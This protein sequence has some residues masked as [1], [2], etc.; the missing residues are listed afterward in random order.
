[1]QP[2]NVM[3]TEF[4]KNNYL[5]FSFSTVSTCSVLGL[6][7]IL[8]MN[9][10][11]VAEEFFNPS[12]LSEDP[13][14]VADLSRF[15]NDGAQAPGKYRVDVYVNENYLSTRDVTFISRSDKKS[16]STVQNEKKSDD[17]GLKACFTLRQLER[18]GVDFHGTPLS[19][20]QS[21]SDCF[22]FVDA[23]PQSASRFDFDKL[24]LYISIPQANM[25]SSVRGYIPPEEW[26]EGVPALLLNYNFSGSNAHSD[27]SSGTLSSYF[28][29]VK[30]GANW[31]AWRLR[32]YST[33]SYS[34]Q[35]RS[36]TNQWQNISTFMQR[37]VIPLK[38]TLQLGDSDTQSDIFDGHGFRGIQLASDDNMMPDSMRGFAPI[39]RGVAN[40]NAQVTV[41]QNGYTIYQSYVSPGAF[42]INDL[43]STASSG[44]LQVTVK[45]A[46]GTENTFTVP[47]SA[48]PILQR[49]GRLKYTLTVGQFRSNNTSQKKP[50]FG[51]GTAIIGLPGGITLYG[52][53]QLANHYRSFVLGSGFN[54]GP[55]GAVSADITQ[56]NSTLADNSQHQ[57]QSLRFL[58]AKS[59]ND[60]G[61]NFQLLGYRYSTQGFYTLDET[62]YRTM[63]GYN[64]SR[65]DDPKDVNESGYGDYYNLRYS[66]KGRVQ[67]NITQQVGKSGSIYL[68]GSRQSYWHNDQTNDLWQVGFNGFW[69]DIN[70]SLSWSYNKNP[71]YSDAD[72]R[73]ALNLSLP[74]GKWLTRGGK[75]A[76][77]T[78][79]NNSAYA[80]YSA[81]RDS[82]GN[83]TQQAGVS[84]TL[85]DSNNLNYN[86]QQGYGNHGVGGSGNAGLDYQGRYG[87]SNV[88]YSYSREYRQLNYGLSGGVV[89]H[90]NGITLSQPLGD[91]NV[92]IKAPGASSVDLENTTGV[93]TDWRG[94]AVMPY[95]N[96][97][98]LNRIALDTTSLKDDADV[99]DAVTNVVP[100]WGALSLAEFTTRIGRRGLITLS[101]P[102]GKF[103]P[104]GA[105]ASTDDSRSQSIVGENGQVYLSGLLPEG[106]LEVKWGQGANQM[107]RAKYILPK[108]AEGKPIAFA[109]SVC[110]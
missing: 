62:S 32:N 55:F 104:F 59:L 26:D 38:S 102:N 64:T 35:N 14:A 25:K 67:V 7:M 56:A 17:T 103:V 15:S 92:L 13:D 5:K 6:C 78:S 28:L 77:I 22:D 20:N 109:T 16:K 43:Y 53:S 2:F 105:V 88:N 18:L 61:T 1:M 69:N 68:S 98:R 83:L 70:Y 100:T 94:Y 50:Y 42:E 10:F 82:H 63:N 84:G 75:G 107:C 8:M 79:S 46:N 91:T 40:S 9:N 48:V 27:S 41:K 29:N 33:W 66:K 21:P 87:N 76:D 37:A 44:N 12:F 89:A 110:K 47:Y 93:S 81:N 95:A 58:Y 101:Q 108:E 23:I 3:Q 24:R 97:Y 54:L 57:G 34:K 49:E 31:G 19:K 52:G 99:D 45:E 74:L 51:Q 65:Q 90:A 4:L 73:M 96:D 71:G 36:T 39:I 60:F 86:V 85:L 72:K 30:S 80:T 106:D 11:A